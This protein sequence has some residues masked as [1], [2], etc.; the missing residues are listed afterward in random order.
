MATKYTNAI[1]PPLVFPLAT[2]Q[3]KIGVATAPLNTKRVLPTFTA[4]KV[5]WTAAAPLR[6]TLT[7]VNPTTTQA[8]IQTLFRIYPAPLNGTSVPNPPTS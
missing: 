4:S 7:V 3:T 6:N 1:W 5:N 8:Q 2:N